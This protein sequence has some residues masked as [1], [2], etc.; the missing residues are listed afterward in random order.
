MANSRASLLGFF[1]RE[2]GRN[3][4]LQAWRDNLLWLEVVFE[5]LETGDKNTIGETLA[6]C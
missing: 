3:A 1:L 2:A 4:N 6:N 5:I